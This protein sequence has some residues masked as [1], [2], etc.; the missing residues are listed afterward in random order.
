MTPKKRIILW[1]NIYCICLVRIKRVPTR[2]RPF[3][4][5]NKDYVGGAT[6][7]SFNWVCNICKCT[8]IFFTIWMTM[9]SIYSIF[10]VL[11]LD[12]NKPKLNFVHNLG[13]FDW[14]HNW[15]LW[16]N[17]EMDF[18]WHLESWNWKIWSDGQTR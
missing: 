10:Y 12:H 17:W 5:Q 2:Q 18:S 1:Y 4:R 14:Q 16:W 11:H 6:C 7:W 15:I 9:W 13:P 8:I 3:W